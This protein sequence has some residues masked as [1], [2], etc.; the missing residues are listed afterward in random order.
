MHPM[1]LV[2]Q[3]IICQKNNTNKPQCIALH[4]CHYCVF[5]ISEV[6]DNTLISNLHLTV[7]QYDSLLPA[8]NSASKI[9]CLGTT[10]ICE[11]MCLAPA[12][13]P[14]APQSQTDCSAPWFVMSQSQSFI[15]HGAGLHP[16]SHTFRCS[17]WLQVCWIASRH[18]APVRSHFQTV[19]SADKY[20]GRFCYSTANFNPHTLVLCLAVMWETWETFL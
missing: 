5:Q 10:Q 17:D 8:N 9:I 12:E 14:A 15:Q 2:L 1:C 6:R 19:G 16:M 4:L 20:E 7:W 18:D 13:T 11:L 3:Y